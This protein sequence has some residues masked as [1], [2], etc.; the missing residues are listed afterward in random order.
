L[1]VVL[2][3]FA[4][5][6]SQISAPLPPGWQEQTSETGRVF[7]VNHLTQKTTYLVR[8]DQHCG[9]VWCSGQS[10]FDHPLN[11]S[12]DP[13]V[14]ARQ[15]KKRV[16]SGTLSKPP[17]YVLDLPAKI[18]SIQ[19]KLAIEQSTDFVI[20][21][22]RSEL[23]ED[24]MGFLEGVDAWTLRQRLRIQFVGE[25]GKDFGGMSREWFLLL[26]RQL[27][28][29]SR[30]LFVHTDGYRLEPAAGADVSALRF[31]GIVCGLAVIHGMVLS[32][33]FTNVVYKWLMGLERVEDDSDDE[34]VALS[35]LSQMDSSFAS[36]MQWMLD[37]DVD[38]LD[39]TFVTP[40]GEPLV[41]GGAEMTVT[42]A[43][44]AE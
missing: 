19:A 15:Q 39:L 41:D 7:Y 36:S 3:V 1:V 23:V 37:N 12:Q 13:R 24:S 20:S 30:G 10:L 9:S 28:D 8:N 27:S 14:P 35:E 31:V 43:N 17:R 29:P 40:E 22:R 44:K 16:L 25:A 38:V 2:C 21:V 4:V 33:P 42:N 34:L 5:T 26:S 18:A 32:L 11:F 6:L